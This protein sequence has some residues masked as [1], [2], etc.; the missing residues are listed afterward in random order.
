MIYY[1][2]ITYNSKSLEVEYDECS[3]RKFGSQLE[4]T[5]N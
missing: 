5:T 3:N 1:D 4:N 2:H